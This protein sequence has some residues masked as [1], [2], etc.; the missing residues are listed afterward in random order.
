[1]KSKVKLLGIA[2]QASLESEYR[3]YR[4]TGMPHSK[5]LT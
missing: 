2:D 1:M 4:R 5:P 3:V